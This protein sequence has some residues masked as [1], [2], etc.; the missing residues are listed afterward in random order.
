M[1]EDGTTQVNVVYPKFKN[2]EGTVR[3]VRVKPIFGKTIQHVIENLFDN[4]MKCIT[5]ANPL[6][7]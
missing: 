1:K 7:R 6:F 3:D 4:E 5:I 2:G